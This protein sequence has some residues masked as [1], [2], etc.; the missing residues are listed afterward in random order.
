MLTWIIEE[1]IKYTIPFIWYYKKRNILNRLVISSFIFWFLEFILYIIN[2]KYHID[3]NITLQYFILLRLFSIWM[4]VV[5]TV[6]W[7]LLSWHKLIIGFIISSWIHII[8]NLSLIHWY[9][10]VSLFIIITWT[11]SV[12]D[13]IINNNKYFLNTN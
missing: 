13:N 9:Y 8:Y 7:Y 11:I 12:I 3:N 10:I 1:L 4:H 6:H 2:Y 5:I